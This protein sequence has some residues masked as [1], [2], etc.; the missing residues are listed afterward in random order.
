MAF[1]HPLDFRPKCGPGHQNG[2]AQ[3]NK[4]GSN[5]SLVGFYMGSMPRVEIQSQL[6][7]VPYGQA[8]AGNGY[9]GAQEDYNTAVE[10]L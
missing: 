7:G 6:F 5:L 10:Y 3:Y 9:P 8:I 1:K 2:G 4:T